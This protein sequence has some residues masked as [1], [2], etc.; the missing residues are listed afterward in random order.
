M[1][2]HAWHALQNPEVGGRM[3]PDQILDLCRRAG[4]TEEA[5]QKAA[6]QRAEERLDSQVPLFNARFVHQ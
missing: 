1:Q 5:A 6:S 4:Y 2:T 3:D